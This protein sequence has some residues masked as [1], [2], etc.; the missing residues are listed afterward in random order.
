MNHNLTQLVF[1]IECYNWVTE[2]LQA[3]DVLVRWLSNQAKIL[4]GKHTIKARL[5]IKLVWMRLLVL[6]PV[7][8]AF[9]SEPAFAAGVYQGRSFTQTFIKFSSHSQSE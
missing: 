1:P 8:R 2:R 7:Q 4:T 6:S 5:P 3:G 9:T